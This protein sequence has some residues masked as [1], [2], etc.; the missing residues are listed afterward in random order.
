MGSTFSWNPGICWNL[1]RFSVQTNGTPASS[2][3]ELWL[4]GG[5]DVRHDG[6]GEEGA[7]H[8]PLGG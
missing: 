1:T 8:G 7:A 5:Q 3:V 6:R 2:A 4:P